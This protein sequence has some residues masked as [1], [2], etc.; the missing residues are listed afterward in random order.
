M[1]I[2]YRDEFE[3]AVARATVLRDE[4]GSRCGS[5]AE[6][7]SDTGMMQLVPIELERLH[8]EMMD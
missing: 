3:A 6:I 2:D 1:A 4:P 8:V 5:V 7:L